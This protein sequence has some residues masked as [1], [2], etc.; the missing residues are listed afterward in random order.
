MSAGIASSTRQPLNSQMHSAHAPLH[1]G[2]HMW[3]CAQCSMHGLMHMDRRDIARHRW[4]IGRFAAVWHTQDVVVS[5]ASPG[6]MAAPMGLEDLDPDFAA[7][8]GMI[9]PK[10]A[11]KEELEVHTRAT[12]RWEQR[13][14]A[15]LSLARAKLEN[16]RL[17]ERHRK[18]DDELS[19]LKSRLVFGACDSPRERSESLPR[20]VATNMRRCVAVKSP[21]GSSSTPAAHRLKFG[22]NLLRTTSTPQTSLGTL[23]LSLRSAR[24]KTTS[25]E[26]LEGKRS[27]DLRLGPSLDR[28]SFPRCSGHVAAYK[29]TLREVVTQGRA[30]DAIVWFASTQRAERGKVASFRLG[31]RVQVVLVRWPTRPERQRWGRQPSIVR[32][33]SVQ[34][35]SVLSP[36]SL[37]LWSPRA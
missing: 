21:G 30:S 31:C 15:L 10:A 5:R 32:I 36:A 34:A 2:R 29:V 23:G 11:D 12:P 18:T 35:H 4:A 19:A 27:I 13:S 26:A 24:P 16:V 7:L 8:A 6:A 3:A 37:P 9:A 28:L 17:Q 22:R 25:P 1:I 33:P 20:L 14:P